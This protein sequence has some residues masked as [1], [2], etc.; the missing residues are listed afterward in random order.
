MRDKDG[1][2]IGHTKCLN[3]QG[4]EK[5]GEK[6]CCGGKS[7]RFAYVKCAVRGKILAEVECI[8]A[9]CDLRLEKRSTK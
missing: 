4:V 6:D 9:C 1:V 5:Y 8:T 2:F 7:T 3:W